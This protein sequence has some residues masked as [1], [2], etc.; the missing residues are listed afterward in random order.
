[1][2][3]KY[4]AKRLFRLIPAM[5][6]LLLGCCAVTGCTGNGGEETSATGTQHVEES[7][8]PTG[9]DQHTETET[10]TEPWTE[11][12]TTEETAE[13]E[14]IP[15][16]DPAL[17]VFPTEGDNIEIGIFWEPP[18]K[19]T[20]PQQYD[21]IRDAH[22]TFIE[23]T[24]RELISGK[25][26]PQNELKLAAER[27]IGVTYNPGADG[28][29]IM[30][31]TDAQLVDYLT[32]LQDD[33][34]I[35]GI[36]VVDEPT[37]PWAYGRVC[38]IIKQNG[39]CARLNFLPSFATWVFE[40]YQGH[41][42]D[43]IIATGR[44]NYS[45]LSYDQYPFPY[46]GGNPSA[47]YA[48]LN[49][50]REIGL[51]YDVPTAFYIQSIGEHGN[52][53]RTNGNEIR[54]HTSAGLA[55]GIKSYT[56]FTW[57]TTG[58]CDPADYGIISP[59]GEKTDI[60]DDVAEI[61]AQ[62]LKVGRLLRR[63]DAL[64]VYHNRGTEAGVTSLNRNTAPI[65]PETGRFIVSLMQDR[66]TGRDYIMLVNKDY[67][68]ETT[69]EFSLSD[70]I[71]HLYNCTNAS[72]EEMDISS[73]KVTLT[74]QPGGFILLAVGQ[75]DNIVDKVVDVD[76]DNLAKNKPVS[77]SEVNPGNGW[78][79]Y[80]L[81]DGNRTDEN[82]VGRGWRTSSEQGFVTV[83]FLRDVTFNRVDLY[84]TGSGYDMAEA[85]PRDFAIQFSVDGETWIDIL[86]K[87]D[88]K[89]VA[90]AVPSF[91]FEA[92]TARYVRVY[93]T[94]GTGSGFALA[95]IEVFHDDGSLP[96]ADSSHYKTAGGEDD[97]T[98]VAL[99]RPVTA[100]SN[101]AGW[102]PSRLTDGN[103]GTLWS[104][105]LNRH[106]TADE[107]EY[108]TVDLMNAYTLD[109]IV[110]IPR[111]ND[112]YFPQIFEVQVSDDG[113]TFTTVKTVE[114]PTQNKGTVPITVKLE[115]TVQARYVR[116]RATKLR[117]LAGFGD[118][119][120]FQLSEIEIYNK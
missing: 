64:E 59:Y 111:V 6:L 13:S 53:R 83:D 32:R 70:R 76:K 5:A 7:G 39:L 68:K 107:E 117:D 54:L 119:F 8:E 29:N 77:V 28:K 66:E 20:T 16:E 116:I 79:A 40:N 82:S 115:D 18:A 30:S 12:G 4:L 45:Y 93:V 56:Y 114:Y 24:N 19:F 80:T 103:H 51:K 49:Q 96:P 104:S 27:G 99:N 63:L 47:M 57:W 72:Y 2:R 50:F 65:Y 44:E 3:M 48:N 97:G 90:N 112:E 21:W 110:L 26:G 14:T 101:L 120:L 11:S 55:Y 95:E 74:F 78:Y 92:V 52:F 58:F 98:N 106:A 73:G 81:T 85:F 38:R 22:I 43:T 67:K 71:T 42:E 109:R 33:P 102:D 91:Q 17:N 86:T 100:S 9:S 34:T 41:V 94:R 88:Y 60:Y 69:A 23:M 118:G 37:N 89:D 61:N 75:H 87:T 10:P 25:D 1:M 46:N 113:E 84:P 15:P 105:A 35:I 108:F 36:H 62:V 31:M